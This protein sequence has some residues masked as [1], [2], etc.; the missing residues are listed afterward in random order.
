MAAFVSKKDESFREYALTGSTW[1]VLLAVCLPLA[2]YQALHSIFNVMDTLMA[3][4]ISSDSV[5]AVAVLN[6]IRTM[7]SA[8]GNGLAIGGCIKISEAY[9]RGDYDTVRRQVATLYAM[10]VAVGGLVIL[11][12]VP[13][14]RPFL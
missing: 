13:F 11:V 4:H 9:G 2:L 8:L 12:L 5:S 10:A 3:S 6:Q 7:I 14:A 1:K